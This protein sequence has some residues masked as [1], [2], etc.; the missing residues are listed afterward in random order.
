M[1]SEGNLV[2]AGGTDPLLTTI[3]S[4][5]P[6]YVYFSVDERALQRYRKERDSQ[7]QSNA[8]GSL[9]ESKIKIK[10]GLETDD[11]YPYEAVMD[12]ADNQVDRTTGT[13]LARGVYNDPQ[14]KLTSGSRVR[15]RVPTSA[16]HSVAL[17]P[18]TAI[19]SPGTKYLLVVDDKNIVQR[20]DV[21]RGKPW[22]MAYVILPDASAAPA[23]R[24]SHYSGPPGRAE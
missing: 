24:P 2:N 4:I 22:M 18:D 17:I 23:T 5:D 11:G 3:V 20:H 15:I 6:I 21:N 8:A 13:I 10:F 19:L 16:E 1:L 7:G 12:F 9:K 14:G